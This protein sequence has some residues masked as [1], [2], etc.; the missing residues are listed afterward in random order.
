MSLN[1]LVA[2]KEN[3]A[4]SALPN[5]LYERE[6]FFRNWRQFSLDA[7]SYGHILYTLSIISHFSFRPGDLTL[8]AKHISHLL[9]ISLLIF[10]KL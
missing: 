9:S 6:I 2:H 10:D 3:L 7:S 5:D 1:L 4:E 8:R